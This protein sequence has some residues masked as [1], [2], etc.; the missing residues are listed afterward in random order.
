MQI[1]FFLLTPQIHR[2]K[3]CLLSKVISIFSATAPL[4]AGLPQVF[5]VS[6]I[7][8]INV[9]QNQSDRCY[10]RVYLYYH[11]YHRDIFVH[12]IRATNLR[13]RRGC[14]KCERITIRPNHPQPT[15]KKE[16]AKHLPIIYIPP[17]A[18][19]YIHPSLLTPFAEAAVVQLTIAQIYT[20][21]IH[22]YK[23]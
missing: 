15:G 5:S 3:E 13:Q 17:S 12:K 6:K 19:Y 16:T 23:S 14:R 18:V 22:I 9:R 10:F 8:I 7:R 1:I 2:K 21:C 11:R 4:A 20:V